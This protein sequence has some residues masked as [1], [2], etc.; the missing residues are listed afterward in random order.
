MTEQ[1]KLETLR[2]VL[3]AI[4]AI[5]AAL[6]FMSADAV[7]SWINTIMQISGPLVMVV[8]IVWGFVAN[9]KA[10]LV[11]AVDG[12]E[13]VAGVVTTN[14]TEGRELANSIPSNTVAAAGTGAA[15]SLAK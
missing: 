6:G 8:S 7:A 9:R 11:A 5:V 3:Q 10:N 2:Q 4:G 12:M 15:A 14:T 13:G 1:Q